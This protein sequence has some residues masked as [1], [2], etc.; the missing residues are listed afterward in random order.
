MAF[1]SAEQAIAAAEAKFEGYAA[2]WGSTLE[3]WRGRYCVNAD[4]PGRICPGWEAKVKTIKAEV[5]NL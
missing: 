3:A 2:R 1:A 4:Y 5:E